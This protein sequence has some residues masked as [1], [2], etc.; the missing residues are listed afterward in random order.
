M[1]INS[2]ELRN[3]ILKYRALNNLSQKEMAKK[4][5]VGYITLNSFEKGIEVKPITKIKMQEKLK[6]LEG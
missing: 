5:N 2:E 6:E 1:D 3:S 4:L